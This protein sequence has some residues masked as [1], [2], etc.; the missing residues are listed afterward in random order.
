MSALL[1]NNSGEQEEAMEGTEGTDM[2]QGMKSEKW[3]KLSY[4]VEAFN[5]LINRLDYYSQG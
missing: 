2:S 3:L 5:L 4:D 1:R